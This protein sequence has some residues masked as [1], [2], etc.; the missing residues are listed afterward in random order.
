MAVLLSHVIR[1]RQLHAKVE[2]LTVRKQNDQHEVIPLPQSKPGGEDQDGG[3]DP[4]LEEVPVEAPVEEP[5][6]PAQTIDAASDTSPAD[7]Q[8]VEKDEVKTEIPSLPTDEA[9]VGDMTVS[10]AEPSVPAPVTTPDEVKQESPE[11]VVGPDAE[12]EAV[13]WQ[14]EAATTEQRAAETAMNADL[15]D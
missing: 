2:N 9:S 6:S 14:P 3:H 1:C 7:A 10:M 13:P 11:Q 5:A 8:E 12:A 4:S 15:M